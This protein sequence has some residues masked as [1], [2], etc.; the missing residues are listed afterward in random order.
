MDEGSWIRLGRIVALLF[1]A[2]SAVAYW[3]LY[4]VF[5]A[6]KI[7]RST[8]ALLLTGILC[9]VVVT[10]SV[11]EV[12]KLSQTFKDRKTARQIAHSRIESVRDEL[13]LSARGNPIG[14][15]IRY[16]VEY[17]EGLDDLR[18]A[19]FANVH[20]DDPTANLSTLNKEVRPAI[21]G[22]GKNEFTEDFG[23]NFLPAG[24]IFPGSQDL[25][26]RWQSKE[27]KAAVLRSAPQHYTIEIEP[28]RYRSVTTNA[29]AFQAFYEGALR[30]GA[31]ECP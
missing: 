30:E 23:P 13:L 19:P 3:V 12:A 8:T 26:L 15:R 25:C 16:R 2:V 9:P 27:G 11:L 4:G 1:A 21:I 20:V 10:T 6:R 28:F 7:R 5:W 18:Y 17:D 29:Y 24:F 14:V 22:S 31:K